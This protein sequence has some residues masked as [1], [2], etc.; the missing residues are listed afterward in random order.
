M[1][2]Y[3]I[4]ILTIIFY[5]LIAYFL[6]DYKTYINVSILN[7]IVLYWMVFS[8]FIALFELLL[9][10]SS[11]YI[12][13][14]SKK[15]KNFWYENIPISNILSYTFWSKGWSE[16]GFFCDSR[17]KEKKNIVHY[18]ELI[19]AITAFIY[20]YILYHYVRYNTIDTS[21]IGKIMISIST[22]HL[23]FTLIYFI[24]FLFNFNKNPITTTIKFW[25]YLLLNILWIVFPS[26][27]LL[28][29]INILYY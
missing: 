17:Y 29:G 8:L 16:Y 2:T 18:I 23:L 1:I 20:V 10:T 19:H 12:I 26:L 11:D 27:V 3:L 5:L 7:R 6:I 13:N 22:I 28:K 9:F 24:T 21:F 25:V 4:Y 15:Q 14:I